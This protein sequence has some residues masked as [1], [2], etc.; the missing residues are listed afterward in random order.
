M[1]EL[2]TMII[3]SMVC[4][5]WA[6]INL[7]DLNLIIFPRIRNLGNSLSQISAYNVSLL[8][9]EEILEHK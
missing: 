8:S 5:N 9:G 6:N 7:F 1:C 4:N 3:L 2:S